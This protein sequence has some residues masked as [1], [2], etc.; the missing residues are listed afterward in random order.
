MF[1]FKSCALSLIIFIHCSIKFRFHLI[2]Y[3]HQRI[4]IQE[5]NSK[6]FNDLKKSRNLS[7]PVVIQGGI[8]TTL[9]SFVA[10]N[11]F[12]HYVELFFESEKYM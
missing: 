7:N 4:Y 12:I 6:G 3:W 9:T 8:V 5:E 10:R 2:W 1:N 11:V